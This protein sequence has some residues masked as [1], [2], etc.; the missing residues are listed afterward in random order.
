MDLRKLFPK[1][2]PHYFIKNVTDYIDCSEAHRKFA[3]TPGEFAY[4]HELLLM[5]V[6]MSV[7]D[8]ELSSREIERITQTDVGYMYMAGMK[9]PNYHIILRFK[10]DYSDLIDEAFKKTIKI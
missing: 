8:G 1:D 3:D 10:H 6:L 9:H 7:F 4:P 5:L 2:H